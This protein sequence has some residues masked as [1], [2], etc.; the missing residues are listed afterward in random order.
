MKYES[1]NTVIDRLNEFDGKYTYIV[2]IL[3]FEFEMV[4]I[5]HWPKSE[6]K[7]GHSTDSSIWLTIP[8]NFALEPDTLKKWSGKKVV[9]G[10]IIRSPAKN[11]GGCGHLAGWPCEIEATQLELYK[12]VS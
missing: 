10:G 1:V 3:E 11:V 4:C 2:G 7:G 5:D 12:N 9:A 8:L 6:H